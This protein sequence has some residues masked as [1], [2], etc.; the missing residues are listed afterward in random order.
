MKAFLV[1]LAAVNVASL[2]AVFGETQTLTT[3]NLEWFP[4]RNPAPDFAHEAIQI[5]QVHE[6]LEQ[7]A[8]DILLLQEV[9]DAESAELAV[10]ILPGMKVQVVSDFPGQFGNGQQL[11]IASKTDPI[12]SGTVSFPRFRGDPPRGF[13]FARYQLGDGQLLVYNV[14]LKSNNGGIAENI[15]KREIAIRRFLA[16]CEKM[17]E[18]AR[19]AG[20]GDLTIILG[21]DYNSDPS[22]PRFAAEKS[23]ALL[24]DA[25]FRWAL[26]DLAPKDRVTWPGNGT[27]P[28][29]C[30]DH[31][32]YVPSKQIEI[33]E[34]KVHFGTERVSDHR[35][36]SLKLKF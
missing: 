35:A 36:V 2:S 18:R 20:S 29:A 28:D 33:L 7:L 14:H 17:K 5:S 26:R 31:F 13:V 8:P 34:P 10:R 11:V 27:Y 3:W 16:H 15:P 23:T 12:E 30:L 6:E 21:G 32:F 25:G 4:G 1:Y 19:K 22:D 9:R 24:N